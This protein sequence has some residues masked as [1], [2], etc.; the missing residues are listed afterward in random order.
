MKRAL[1]G[2]CLASNDDVVSALKDAFGKEVCE[3][4]IKSLQ[5][6]MADVCQV[7]KRLCGKLNYCNSNELD[8][9]TYQSFLSISSKI[10]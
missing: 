6:S 7:T 9:I 10:Y 2:T 8:L 3:I 4:E 1:A 5:A